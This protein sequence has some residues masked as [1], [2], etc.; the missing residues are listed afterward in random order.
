MYVH[1]IAL[2]YGY[3][4]GYYPRQYGTGLGGYNYY[5]YPGAGTVLYVDDC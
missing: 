1:V 4:G 5:S 2:G 3:T